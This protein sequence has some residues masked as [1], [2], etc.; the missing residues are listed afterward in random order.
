[1][2]RIALAAFVLI[3]LAAGHS[4]A[5]ETERSYLMSI[6]PELDLPLPPDPFLFKSAGGLGISGSYV[7]PFFRPWS[8]GAEL[9]YHLARM[10]HAD[11]GNLGSLSLISVSATT[12]MRLTFKELIDAYLSIGAGY[13]IAFQNGEA[14]SWASNIVLNGRIGAGLRVTPMITV[15]IQGEYRRYLR[16]YHLVGIGIGLDLRLGGVK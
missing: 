8:A 9:D 10:R 4:F 6:N 13:F 12:E 7:F 16:L 1:V 2:K 15:G 3:F 5:Q 11:L 14:S